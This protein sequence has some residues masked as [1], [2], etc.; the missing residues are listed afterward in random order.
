M[1]ARD[2]RPLIAHLVFRFDI[3]GLENG[4]VNLV[5]GL[6]ESEFRHVV[7]A[8]TEATDFRLR[9]A[10]DDVRVHEIGKRPG[11]DP[12]AYLRL[13]RLLRELQPDIIH[14]RNLA[15]L[16]CALVAALARVPFRIHGEH[17]WD[18]HDQYGNILKY[19][20]LRRII[21][22]F[23][24]QFVTVSRDLREWLVAR[25][26]I[27][28][29]KVLCICNGV[30][31]Q[32]FRP[33]AISPSSASN[34]VLIGSVTRFQ[35]IK[36]PLNLVR[37]FVEAR[38]GLAS[39]GVNLRLLM[40][41]DGPLRAEAMALLES[42]GASG[43]ASLP[44][45]GSDV[46]EL[47]RTLN[48]FVLGSR[49]EGISNTILEAM[50]TGLPVIASATGGNLELIVPEM[51]GKLVPPGDTSALA[52]AIVTYALDAEMR[53]R[54]GQAARARAENEYSLARMLEDYRRLYASCGAARGVAA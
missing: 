3:G 5:N 24:Q 26:G 11:K 46:P 22:P 23:I 43:A 25:V 14:T 39:R 7:I 36:D 29:R 54:H 31:T 21:N 44:G 20:V 48:L 32:R 19:K 9:I 40:L 51:T 33:A 52:D 10:R 27:P 28:A 18:V 2:P 34:I 30:D 1:N 45:G 37:A 49:R 41:G 17:G 12:K 53:A 38:R 42:A 13:Y 6:P 16:E 8:L 35:E 15:T 4:V 50:A 47:L